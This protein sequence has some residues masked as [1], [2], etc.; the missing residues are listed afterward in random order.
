M[1]RPTAVQGA[2]SGLA[3]DG[4]GCYIASRFVTDRPV[5][6]LFLTL[7]KQTVA[8]SPSFSTQFDHHGAWR[9]GFSLRLK[10]LVEWMR[11]HELVNAAV[12][13]RLKRLEERMRTDKV[14][15]AFVAEFSRGKSEL[16]NALFFADF[17]RRMMPASAGRTTMCPTEI[18]YEIG[19]GTSL[20]L[21]PIATRLQPQTLLEWRSNPEQWLR[22]DLDVNNPTELATALQKVSETSRVP[23]ELARSLGFWH[24]G[25]PLDNPLVGPDDLVEVPQWRHAL[26]NIAHPLLRQGLVILDTP[27]LNAIGAEPELTVNLLPQADAVVFLLAADTGV[28]QSDLT[29][30]HDHL[31]GSDPQMSTRLVVLNKIDTLWDG[32]DSSEEVKAQ[33]DRQ[34]RDASQILGVPL[35]KVLAVSAQKGLVAKVTHDAALLQ[36]SCL[37]TLEHALAHDIIGQRQTIL[38]NALAL[39]VGELRL[40]ASRMIHIRRRDLSEQVFELKG[41][42]GKNS[43]VVRQMKGRIDQERAEFEVGGTK[44]QAVKSVH[45]RLLRDV[46]RMLSGKTLADEINQL[47]TA[48]A[49]TGLKFGV[50]KAYGQTFD[51]LR[52][53]MTKAQT[54]SSELHTMLAASYRQLNADFGF[55]LQAPPDLSLAR[56]E[57]DLALV[58]RSHNQYVGLGSALKLAQADTANRL[59]RALKS[60]L[61]IIYESALSELELWSKSATSQLDAQLLERRRNFARR[62]ESIERVQQATGTLSE[63]IAEIDAA[64]QA[65]RVQDA[66]LLALTDALL[67]AGSEPHDDTDVLAEVLPD[68]RPEAPVPSKPLSKI[69]LDIELAIESD[70]AMEAADL[71]AVPPALTVA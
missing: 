43:S 13:E 66:Q 6:H 34:C 49:Q 11:E 45:M 24:D 58:Q 7:S 40:E 27:G 2:L 41:L 29:I 20:R 48:L 3:L 56:Y 25:S 50:K 64:Q 21:L 28:T 63:R 69:K 10:L 47:T 19:Q 23:V 14:M 31:S 37:A 22:I 57:S 15:V 53:G 8:P 42:E 9:R 5:S 26:I 68:A 36:A 55:S 61:R 35:D 33:I 54:A 67:R 17:G 70:G 71:P 1:S 16:I 4:H 46:Y 38:R 30:W 32:L 62:S 52:A 18:G 44:I 51:R 12:E 60:R 65:L 39:A 59:V